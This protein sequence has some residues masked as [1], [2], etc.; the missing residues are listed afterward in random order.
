MCLQSV[1]YVG[2]RM[3]LSERASH[4][5]RHFL[6]VETPEVTEAANCY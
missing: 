3:K 4:R 1:L 2:N 5:Y 6:T